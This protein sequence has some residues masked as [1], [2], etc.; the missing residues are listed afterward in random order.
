MHEQHGTL[1]KVPHPSPSDELQDVAPLLGRPTIT[2]GHSSLKSKLPLPRSD[3]GPGRAPNLLLWCVA[4]LFLPLPAQGRATLGATRLRG[5][6][7]PRQWS[8]VADW[9]QHRTTVARQSCRCGSAST[10]TAQKNTAR[11]NR[12][13]C[14]VIGSSTHWTPARRRAGRQHQRKHQ[15]SAAPSSAATKSTVAPCRLQSE[16]ITCQSSWVP[17]SNGRVEFIEHPLT[18]LGDL[19][20]IV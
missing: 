14:P 9:T 1:V 10:S 19:V 15:G 16:K 12:S 3:P 13:Y 4:L 5:G 18:E 2:A 6:L 11:L 8:L 7:P 17:R 20:F